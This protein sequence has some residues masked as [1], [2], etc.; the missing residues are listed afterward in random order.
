[1][2][3]YEYIRNLNCTDYEMNKLGRER[4]E[5][6][7]ILPTIQNGDFTDWDRTYFFKRT[8]IW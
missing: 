3:Q 6:Y 1:M 7:Q 2:P 8:L 4:W 5:C